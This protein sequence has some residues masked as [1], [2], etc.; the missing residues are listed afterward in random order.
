MSGVIFMA[1]DTKV[2]TISEENNLKIKLNFAIESLNLGI[3]TQVW[4]GSQYSVPYDT[5]F[6]A[7][8][9]RNGKAM[10]PESINWMVQNQNINGSWGNNEILTDSML[11]TASAIANLQQSYKKEGVNHALNK[12]LKWMQDHLMDLDRN[13]FIYT[14]GFEFLFPSL[15]NKIN[16]IKD[17]IDISQIIRRRNEKYI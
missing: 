12:G 11:S 17:N 4:Q 7:G 9:T 1:L 13:D 8:L 5:A 2:N 3:K 14:A 15:L 10:F 16:V 6:V